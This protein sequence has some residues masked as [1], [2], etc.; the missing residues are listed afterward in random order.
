[1]AREDKYLVGGHVR[2]KLRRIRVGRNPIRDGQG[3]ALATPKPYVQDVFVH[4][5]LC[6]AWNKTEELPGKG[7]V[8]Y[9]WA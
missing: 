7:T 8:P 5:R 2:L 3:A 4:K 6:A 1:M 9:S